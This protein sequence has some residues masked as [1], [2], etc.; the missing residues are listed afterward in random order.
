MRTP[1]AGDYISNRNS[2]LWFVIWNLVSNEVGKK[3]ARLAFKDQF[4]KSKTFMFHIVRNTRYWIGTQ[5]Y[6]HQILMK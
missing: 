5:N 4:G 2:T 6:E 1:P 3:A